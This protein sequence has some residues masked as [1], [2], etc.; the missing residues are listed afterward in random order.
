VLSSIDNVDGTQED[1][2]RE[3]EAA[4]SGEGLNNKVKTI[5]IGLMKLYILSAYR[6]YLT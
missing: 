5:G 1:T 4:V 2:G 3:R 6:E